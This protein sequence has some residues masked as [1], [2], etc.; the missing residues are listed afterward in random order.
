MGD[1]EEIYRINKDLLYKFILK[2]C[3]NESLAEELAQETFFKAFVHTNEFTGKCKIST[4][5]CQIAKNEYFNYLKKNK[6]I[7]ALGFDDPDYHG[8]LSFED[9]YYRVECKEQAKIILDI[10]N[11]LPSIYK[12]VFLEK[13]IGD[14]SYSDIAIIHAKSESWARVT[15]YRAKQ[16]ILE[17]MET[18]EKL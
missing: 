7:V 3:A 17:R 11:E 16:K 13:I 9:A 8:S 5:L 6:R 15:F 10:A 4:W 18:Y 2:M 14:L 1:F 12:D